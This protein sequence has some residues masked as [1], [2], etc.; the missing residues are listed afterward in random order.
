MSTNP[1]ITPMPGQVK[2]PTDVVK[3]IAEI[4]KLDDQ[5]TQDEIKKIKP[6]LKVKDISSL[7]HE[8]LA[9]FKLDILKAGD[10]KRCLDYLKAVEAKAPTLHFSFASESSQELTTKIVSWLRSEVHPL[11]LITVGLAPGIGG[12]CYLR[13]TNKVFD[14]SI[15]TKLENSRQQLSD[16]IKDLAR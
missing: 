13:T 7:L 3:L 8:L 14:F 1:S 11:S 4:T 5:L 12:G 15:R 10:R 9:A 16:K 2:T 6:D